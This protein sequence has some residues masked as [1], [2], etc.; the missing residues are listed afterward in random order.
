[1]K[2]KNHVSSRRLEMKK[3]IGDHI[4]IWSVLG[5]VVFWCAMCL[6]KHQVKFEYLTAN[7]YLS[8]FLIL[9]VFAQI[10]VITTGEGA[11]DLSIFYVVS[12]SPY[13]IQYITNVCGNFV[14]GLILTLICCAL[15]GCVNGLINYCLKVPAMIA[16]LATG[17][18]VYSLT[19]V[20]SSKVA[21]VPFKLFTMIAV[22]GKVFGISVRLI[23]TMAVAMIM[24]FI[25][26]RT[27]YGR[28]LHAIGQNRTAAKFSGINVFRTVMISFVISSL[29]AGIAGM[30]LNGY[31]GLAGQD[32][33]DPYMLQCL[34]AA[35]IGGTNINGGK[36]SIFGGVLAGIMWTMLNALLNM[37]GL[38]TSYKSLLQGIAL[39]L[40]LIA[41][42]PKK[43]ANK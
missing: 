12:L 4:W 30:V 36:S 1:M 38:G 37:S 34:A 18:M 22:S 26:Y 21:G 25:L 23:F 15:I 20:L 42:I 41:A 9:M 3:W 14:I 2:G 40:V 10:T 6:M 31:L 13:L 19:I 8:C 29:L 39:L 16:T 27:K 33:G 7:I 35:V 5:I 17:Y 32:T 11:I 24:W 28:R 43:Q